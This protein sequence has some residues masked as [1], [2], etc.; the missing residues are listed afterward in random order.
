[1]E[2]HK[3]LIKRAVKKILRFTLAP[4]RRVCR[5]RD[6]V[7]QTDGRH[8]V[9][10]EVLLGMVRDAVREG[11]TATIWVKGFSMRPFLEHMR[12][13]VIL[14]PVTQPLAEGDAVLAEITPD[15]YV[16]HRI[17]RIE[18]EHI[19]LM[20]DGNLRGTEQ[21]LVKDVAGIVTDYVRPNRTLKATDPK[22]I[23]RIR[24]WRKLLP[25]R[26]LLL[27]IYKSTI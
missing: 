17:I 24:M 27:L 13:K 26:R 11:H 1:M 8:E 18:G 21:C 12:D 22:L 23:H 6:G 5:K 20:G 16:L 10:N 2:F 15:K 25:C 7:V 9:P 14:A 3:W 4:V 19:T